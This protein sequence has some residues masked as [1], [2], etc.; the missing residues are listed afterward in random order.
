MSRPTVLLPP[1]ARGPMARRLS[2]AAARGALELP[3]CEACGAAQYPLRERCGQCCSGRMAWR[4]ALAM[5]TLLS[6]TAIRHSSEP[7]FQDHRPILVGSVLFD[8]GPVAL[9]FLAKGCGASGSRVRILN[10]L[11]RA[12]EAVLVA[13]APDTDNQDGA[14]VMEDPN[15]EIAGKVVLVTGANGGIG[16]ELVAAFRGAGA[17]EVIEIG[18]PTG[19][20]KDGPMRGLD[21]TDRG[22]VATLASAVAE[23]VDILVNN[24]GFNA[25]AGA[26]SPVDGSLA[27]HE[28]DVN[29]F[30]LLN[31]IQSFAPAM[32]ARGQG[33]V[34]N[35]LSILGL[36]SLP[37]IGSYC[38]S[39]AAAWSLTQAA[40]AELAPWGVRVCGVLPG[41][42]DT[43]MSAATPPPKL[44]P[45]QL[46]IEILKA[47]RDGV[48]DVYPGPM[49]ERVFASMRADP[50]A[51]EKEMSSRLPG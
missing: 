42:V 16:R 47:I 3:F 27:R 46:A 30:G 28:M 49:A 23:R 31:M 51:V 10:Q 12:G 1:K 22:A 45:K 36:V 9:M 37:A 25:N 38:A 33:V 24:A 11:D 50:K 8:D 18:G 15:R 32:R 43:R 19:A 29:Y 39:K 13:V 14:N 40:R 41:A 5:G 26:L 35:M 34:V 44:A 4:P 17:A 7:Y 6:Q 21:I 20:A 48:E 2:A